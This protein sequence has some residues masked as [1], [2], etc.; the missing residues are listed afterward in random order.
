MYYIEALQTYN[1]NEASLFLA[2]GITGCPNWQKEIIVK[3]KDL[4]LVRF[5]PR[6]ASFC[7]C[8]SRLSESSGCYYTDSFSTSRC[9]N[10]HKLR[11]TCA[12]NR[13]MGKPGES[14]AI[15]PGVERNLN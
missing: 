13:I 10:C 3:L 7:R 4:P 11:G 14:V 1:G 15:V 2:G 6:R 8:S 9:A 12:R 5:N